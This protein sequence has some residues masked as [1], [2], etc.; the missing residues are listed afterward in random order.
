MSPDR[1]ARPWIIPVFLRQLDELEMIVD[2]Y[3]LRESRSPRVQVAFYGGSFLA[4]DTDIRQ[5]VYRRM[6]PLIR[7]ESLTGGLRITCGPEDV[8]PDVPRELVDGGVKTVEINVCSMHDEVLEAAGRSHTVADAERAVELCQAAGL[9]VGV[10]IHPGLPGSHTDEILTTGERVAGL[11]P[12]FV[13]IYPMLVLEGTELAE[14]YQ[15]GRYNP[16]TLNETVGVCKRLVETFTAADIPVAR[17]GLQPK[18]DLPEPRDVVAGPYHPSLRFLVDAAIAYERAYELIAAEFRFARGLLLRVP[19]REEAALRG[20]KGENLKRLKE[21][22]KL[23]E[24]RIEGCDELAP[25]EL[26]LER[27]GTDEADVMAG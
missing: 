26:V 15:E 22:F 19:V 12:D 8:L 14:L 7:N 9:E 24:L 6:R 2:A 27:L 4:L 3:L 20:E 11:R 18:V 25:G 23:N 5:S 1:R 17:I 16:L 10:R 13:R 21:R